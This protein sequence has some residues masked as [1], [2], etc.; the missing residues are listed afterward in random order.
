MDK[1]TWYMTELTYKGLYT[2]E[3]NAKNEV[4]AKREATRRCAF[5]D[6]I[7][8]IGKGLTR[9]GNVKDV[10]FAKINGKWE[11]Y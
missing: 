8:R 11:R 9:D 1:E 4:A 2:L 7:I 3:L 6:S 5:Y 10:L